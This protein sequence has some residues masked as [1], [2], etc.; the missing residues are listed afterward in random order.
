MILQS[1][2]AVER[3]GK[4]LEQCMRHASF[5]SAAIPEMHIPYRELLGRPKVADRE[6]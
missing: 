5:L 2:T 3:T 6:L 1:L 4:Y